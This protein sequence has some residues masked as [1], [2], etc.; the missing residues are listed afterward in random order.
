[1]PDDSATSLPEPMPGTNGTLVCRRVM[2]TAPE[3]YFQA[4]YHGQVI[5]FCTEFCLESFKAD[6]ERFY[7]AHS[8]KKDWQK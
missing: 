3:N 1:M 8:R 4:E 5:H 6:P 7:L 2:T